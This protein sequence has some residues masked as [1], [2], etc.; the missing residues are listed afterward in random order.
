VCSSDLC[1][2]LR[3]ALDAGVWD[4]AALLDADGAEVEVRA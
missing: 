2:V 3:N 1:E 4:E